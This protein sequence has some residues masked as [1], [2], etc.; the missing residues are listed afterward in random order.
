MILKEWSLK[1]FKKLSLSGLKVSLLAR[2]LYNQMNEGHQFDTSP[3]YLSKRSTIEPQ[4][5]PIVYL[6]SISFWFD[7]V[8]L[9]TDQI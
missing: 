4:R 8:R 7:F 1:R 3:S 5:T 9:D 2:D 6:S